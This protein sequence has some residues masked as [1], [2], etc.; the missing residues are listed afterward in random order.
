MAIPFVISALGD[1]GALIVTGCVLPLAV[2]ARWAGL[3][4]IDADIGVR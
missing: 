2:V 1:T 3:R 4:A